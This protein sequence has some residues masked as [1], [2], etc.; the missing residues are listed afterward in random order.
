[1]SE[2]IIP[3]AKWTI[4]RAYLFILSLICVAVIGVCLWA[5]ISKGTDTTLLHTAVVSSFA[6]LGACIGSYVFGAT[7]QDVKL[8]GRK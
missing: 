4:R 8:L 5:G 1:M 2:H 7:W 3:E 6:L